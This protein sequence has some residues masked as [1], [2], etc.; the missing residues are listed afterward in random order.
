MLFYKRK[1]VVLLP[2]FFLSIDLELNP[3]LIYKIHFC[4]MN[5]CFHILKAQESTEPLSEAGSQKMQAS[6]LVRYFRVSNKLQNGLFELL[7]FVGRYFI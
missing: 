4:S 7:P 5:L 2:L 3:K 1:A 6:L